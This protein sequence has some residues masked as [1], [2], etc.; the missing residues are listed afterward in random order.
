[1][2]N[3]PVLRWAKAVIALL[4]YLLWTIWIG[5]YWLL[6]GLPIVFD[7]YVSKKV[8]WAFWK[9]TKDGKKPSALVEWIDALVFALGAVYLIN[10]FLFQNYKIP[11]SS[12]EKSLLVGDH[13]FVSKVAYGPRMPNTPISFPLVQNTL[14]V[15]NVPSYTEW[16]LWGYRRLA[17]LGQVKH[18]DIVVFNFPAGDTVTVNVTNPSYFELMLGEGLNSVRSNP[19]ILLKQQFNYPIERNRFL[20]ELGRK[21]IAQNSPTYG[22]VVWRP[23]DKRDNYVKRCIALPGDTLEIR[24]NKVYLNGSEADVPEKLQHNYYILTDGTRL[25]EKFFE[26]LQISIED[27]QMGGFGPAYELPLTEDGAQLVKQMPFIRQ[28]QKVETQPDSS[29]LN[30]FPYSSDYHWS[31]DNYGPIWMP[32]K[33]VTITLDLKNISLYERI[34]ANYEGNTLDIRNGKILIN[35][36]ETKEY[37]FQMDYY[38]MLGD[39]RHKS[40]DSRYWGFVPED[41]VVGKPILVWLSLNKDKSFPSNIRWNRFFHWVHRN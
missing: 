4:A 16:P 5:N 20:T 3:H 11:T 24:H 19:Q 14:P 28:I 15:L 22:E 40:A 38:F 39:N 13:L 35:G 36:K 27:Q 1:M 9:K 41:H 37:T 8:P 26:K 33:G 23:V 18:N 32:K 31:R 12:L 10:L 2:H 25:N 34:I 6:L 30:V 17:G 21:A 29:G 7:I